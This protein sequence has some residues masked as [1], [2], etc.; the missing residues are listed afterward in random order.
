MWFERENAAG[1]AGRTPGLLRERIKFLS[2]VIKGAGYSSDLHGALL[3]AVRSLRDRS[4][5]NT[6]QQEAA[7]QVRGPTAW[8]SPPERARPQASGNLPM[9]A[10]CFN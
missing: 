3:G 8:A 5:R 4:D 1:G 7:A 6:A 10:Y 2:R 9:S